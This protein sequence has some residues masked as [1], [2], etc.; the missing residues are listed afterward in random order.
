M[1]RPVPYQEIQRTGLSVQAP[2]SCNNDLLKVAILQ[3]SEAVSEKKDN[4]KNWGEKSKTIPATGSGG[5]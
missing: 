1:L 4:W 5:L 2:S 3:L